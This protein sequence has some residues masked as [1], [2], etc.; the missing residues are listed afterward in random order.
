MLLTAL[1]YTF[2]EG[3]YRT[4]QTTGILIEVSEYEIMIL[5][6]LAKFSRLYQTPYQKK[7]DL[8]TDYCYVALAK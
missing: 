8:R 4:F 6:N 1:K 7:T 3:T 2:Y 5:T